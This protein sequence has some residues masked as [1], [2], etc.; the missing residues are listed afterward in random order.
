MKKNILWTLVVSMIISLLVFAGCDTPTNSENR[1]TTDNFKGKTWQSGP[2]MN[3]WNVW[4]FGTNGSFHLT[5]YHTATN[6]EDRGSHAYRVEDGVIYTTDH[7]GASVSL[8]AVF[9]ADGRSFTLSGDYSGGNRTYTLMEGSL[10]DDKLK[11]KNW[12]PQTANPPSGMFDWY[13]FHASDGTFH[14]YHYMSNNKNYADKGVF[15]YWIIGN[16]LTTLENTKTL[17]SNAG[18]AVL[19][20]LSFSESDSKVTWTP[21]SGSAINLKQHTWE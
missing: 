8:S 1:D 11:G 18:D 21:T 13:E 16:I 17:E 5:H 15:K 3:M 20:T 12:I 7:T 19:Y 4:E 2:K 14:K 6:S 9:A 10:T